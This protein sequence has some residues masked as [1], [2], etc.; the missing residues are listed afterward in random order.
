MAQT[1]ISQSK[2]RSCAFTTVKNPIQQALLKKDVHD[3]SEKERMVDQNRD[4][5]N[6]RLEWKFPFMQFVIKHFG[7]IYII[8]LKMF[9]MAQEEVLTFLQIL[10]DQTREEKI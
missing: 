3:D 6:C 9:K 2:Y 7:E 4:Q 5:K 1:G 8:E 10:V